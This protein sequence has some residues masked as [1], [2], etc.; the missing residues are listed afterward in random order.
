[1]AAVQFLLIRAIVARL[2]AAPYRKRLIRW[3]TDLHD[4]FL[5]PHYLAEDARAVID[6]LE[7][8]G[9]AFEAEWLEPFFE[10]RFPRY[11]TVV[12]GDIS[13]ELRAAI[14]PWLVLGEE[15]TQTG[16][17]RYVDSSLERLQVKTS[18]L[19]AGRHLLTVNGRRIPLRP[20][21]RPGEH[22]AGV[23]YRAW[24]PA[25]ALHPTIGVH[26]PLSFAIVDTWNDRVIGGARYHVSHPGGLAYESFP[27]NALE[28]E[29][30][31]QSRFDDWT[32][33]G[34][35]PSPDTAP[36]VTDRLPQPA[37]TSARVEPIMGSAQLSTVTDTGTD[38]DFPVTLDLR[39]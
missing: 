2:W 20:T 36:G 35:A 12:A 38:P 29:T 34:Q 27:V 13:V 9:I 23:R 30:R 37:I 16:T 22:V 1:M 24:Q 6:D 39:T 21:G 7:A 11:G 18:G 10:F 17:S 26:H 33:V 15:A 4:R 8:A 14:E 31:R 5:L 32:T 19:V 25:S 28:A 3:G